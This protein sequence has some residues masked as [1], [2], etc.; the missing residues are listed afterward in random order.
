MSMAHSLEVRCPFLDVELLEFLSTVP[1][2]MKIRGSRTKRL[3]REVV[4]ERFPK[5]AKRRKH[6][7]EAP[8]GEWINRDLRERVDDLFS[9]A[10][11]GQLFDRSRLMAMLRAHRTQS[12]DL[13]KP[14]W[15]VFVLLQWI[16]SRPASDLGH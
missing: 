13:S 1:L 12:Q 6:G 11:A 5:V 15:A 9:G 8:V 3:L 2:H 7:F 4:G 10:R 14:I 16:E